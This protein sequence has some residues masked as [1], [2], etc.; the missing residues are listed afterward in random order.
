M[1]LIVGHVAEL[2]LSPTYQDNFVR[3]RGKFG[4]LI[5]IVAPLIKS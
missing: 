3:I 1:F 5:D 2:Y 4:I